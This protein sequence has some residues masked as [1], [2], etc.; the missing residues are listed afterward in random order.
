MEGVDLEV[1]AIDS[2][3]RGILSSD[4]EGRRM[5]LKSTI[6]EKRVIGIHMENRARK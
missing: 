3:K 1:Q 4:H 2:T 5:E 6:K